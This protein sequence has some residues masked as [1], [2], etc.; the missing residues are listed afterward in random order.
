MRLLEGEDVGLVRASLVA[1]D[2]RRVEVEGHVNARFE[3]GRA[4]S[5]RAIFRD[6]SAMVREQDQQ[7]VLGQTLLTLRDAG[8]DPA[9]LTQAVAGVLAVE[10]VGLWTIDWDESR[11]QC[12]NVWAAGPGG[13]GA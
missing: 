3:Q 13:G 1:R 2:G 4:V 11:A 5:T 12:L 7:E 10:R 9:A 6:V 8:G